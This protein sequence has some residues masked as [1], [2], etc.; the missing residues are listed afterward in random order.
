MNTNPLFII[1]VRMASTRL[2][3]KALMDIH[4][5]PMIRHVYERTR[6][7]NLGPVIVACD[8]PDVA[9]IITACGGDYVMT[10]PDL[11]SG[12]DR[13]FSALQA[14]DSSGQFD[15]I[16]NVQGDLPTI[17][18]KTLASC[19]K[20]LEHSDIDMATLA[21]AIHSNEELSDPNVVK[22][23]LSLNENGTTGRALYF[24]RACIPHGAV[25]HYHHIGLYA[26]R[27]DTLKRFVNLPP[28]PLEQAERLEQLRA[29]EDGMRIGVGI[30]DK[31]PWGV[32]T[33]E[34]LDRIRSSWH[35]IIE[36]S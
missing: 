10:D 14:R 23:A 18:K 8:H 17:D 13:I 35:S 26:Y 30:I 9:A 4:G 20:P 1:P 28:S 3:Q 33:H 2:A 34:D 5:K 16:V 6:D 36:S 19:L 22:I 21:C 31:A 25:I 11:P 7:A 27:R 12:S 24:S 32:D 15:V 29:L